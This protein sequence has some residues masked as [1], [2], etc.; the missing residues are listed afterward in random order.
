VRTR[1]I[2]KV[3]VVAVAGGQACATAARR[4]GERTCLGG[5]RGDR[6][7]GG[8]HATGRRGLRLVATIARQ[9]VTEVGQNAIQCAW[10]KKV[11]VTGDTY[12][13]RS[14]QGKA[15]S[16]E[17]STGVRLEREKN[18][19]LLP[20]FSGLYVSRVTKRGPP[21]KRLLAKTHLR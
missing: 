2:T 15:L 1:P 14:E 19:H 3:S 17:I 10:C 6:G 11:P 4:G 5:R 21:P 8:G 12:E 13:G 18:S 7:W 16:K 20:F 9:N